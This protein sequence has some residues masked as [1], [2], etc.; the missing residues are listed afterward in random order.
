M[1]PT[2][3]IFSDHRKD[4]KSANRRKGFFVETALL[5]AGTSN[6][7]DGRDVEPSSDVSSEKATVD[8]K[9]IGKADR[10]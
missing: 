1:I 7:A 10:K 6:R 8:E 5:T 3:R 9:Q 2:R 4:A